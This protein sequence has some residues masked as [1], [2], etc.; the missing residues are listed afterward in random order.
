MATSG[1]FSHSGS[2]GDSFGERI[3]WGCDRY[4][5]AGEIIAA[6]HSSP[7]Q[8]IQGWLNSPPHKSIMLD[9]IYKVAGVGFARSQGSETFWTVDFITPVR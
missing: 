7:E 5:Y 6:G 8:V 2:K 3:S 4:S 1:V 9:P